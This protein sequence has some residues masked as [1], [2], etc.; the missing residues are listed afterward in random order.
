MQEASASDQ[1]AAA[2]LEKEC[3]K[4]PAEPAPPAA[5]PSSPRDILQKTGAE[6]ASTTQYQFAVWLDDG[7]GY[8]QSNTVAQPGGDMNEQQASDFNAALKT[9][10]SLLVQFKKTGVPY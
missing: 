7:E 6:A 3:G 10:D 5:A 2:H 8:V 4:A 9:T 1:Q